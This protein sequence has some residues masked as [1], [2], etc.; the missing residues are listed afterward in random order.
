MVGT[1]S[2]APPALIETPGFHRSAARPPAPADFILLNPGINWLVR[3]IPPLPQRRRSLA[4]IMEDLPPDSPV[5][6]SRDRAEYLLG[7][8]SPKHR[9]K[10]G[11]MIQGGS[12]S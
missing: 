7:Q 5:W 6:R 12:V 4:G 8:M 2:D 1:A 11:A 3:P 9:A 10:A